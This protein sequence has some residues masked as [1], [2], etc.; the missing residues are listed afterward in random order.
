M[1]VAYKAEI[2]TLSGA[3]YNVGFKSGMRR[4]LFVSHAFSP[5]IV[6][7]L[8]EYTRLNLGTDPDVFILS[9]K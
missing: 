2:A 6:V 8:W 4:K 7:F 5:R 1:F 9:M 3:V